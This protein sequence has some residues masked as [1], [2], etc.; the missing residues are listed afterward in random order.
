MP[1]IY[2]SCYPSSKTT[3]YVN[4]R[5][6][7]NILCCLVVDKTEHGNRYEDPSSSPLIPLPT[8]LN[9]LLDFATYP[10]PRLKLYRDN[11]HQYVV[12]NAYMPTLLPH[13]CQ[14]Y[15]HTIAHVHT[16]ITHTQANITLTN[17]YTILPYHKPELT[18]PPPTDSF[19]L[20][21]PYNNYANFLY[22]LSCRRHVYRISCLT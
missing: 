11:I 1:Y 8:T 6:A 3:K 17:I 13:L 15:R 19:S 14:L 21:P 5:S 9:A 7:L 20:R 10:K 2:T 22:H 12:Y 18:Y 4:I 16:Y